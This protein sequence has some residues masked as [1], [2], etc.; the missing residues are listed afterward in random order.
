[1][2]KFT[3]AAKFFKGE[4]Q[5]IDAFNYLQDHTTPE[6]A[7]EFER[8]YRSKPPL[9]P[10]GVSLI[11]E[12]EGCKLNAYPDPLTKGL[13]IT[14]GW[15]STLDLN[16]KAFRMG[17]KVTQGEADELLVR[18][19]TLDYLPPLKRIPGWDAMS[20]QMQG[21]LLSFAYNLGANFYGSQ[22]FNTIS[23]C[24]KEKRWK[25]V[26]A[27]LMLYVNPGTNVTEGLKRRRKAEGDLWSQGLSSL[28]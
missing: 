15:G 2:I 4:P 5:Q 1:M 18:Q 27:A 25:D 24:L 3:D 6:V 13:P 12:F 7:E 8:R 20:E 23:S 17:D 19:L 22:G 10:S 9:P 26:P 14:I 11:K 16:N 21:C 28:N